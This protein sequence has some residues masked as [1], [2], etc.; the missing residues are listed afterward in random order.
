MLRPNGKMAINTPIMPVPKKIIG[1]QHTRHLKNINNDIEFTILNETRFLRYSLS[2]WQKQTSKL[3]FGSYPYPGN[4]L[5]NN[6][7]E[8]INVFQSL[9]ES[10]PLTVPPDAIRRFKILSNIV[11]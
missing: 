5:E 8:F 9:G 6:T 2:I 4:I 10:G 7:V 11:E 1:G 3:M